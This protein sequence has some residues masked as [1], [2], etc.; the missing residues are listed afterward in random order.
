M[1]ERRTKLLVVVLGLVLLTVG[2]WDFGQAARFKILT[3]D[4][5]WVLDSTTYLQWQRMPG[6]G[7][8]SYETAFTYCTN[9]GNGARLPEIKELLNLVDYSVAPGPVLPAGHPFLNV[10]SALYWSATPAAG[11]VGTE[12]YVDFSNGRVFATFTSTSGNAW[13]VR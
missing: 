8:M 10:Q 4:P 1:V 2:I 7:S 3:K 11:F 5:D 6:V 13:C 9:L 12:W